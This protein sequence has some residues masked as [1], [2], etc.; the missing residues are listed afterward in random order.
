MLLAG[1]A[2]AVAR[3]LHDVPHLVNSTMPTETRREYVAHPW[4]AYLHIA[5][6][7]WLAFAMHAAFAEW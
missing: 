7:F 5:V 4:R 6:A 3:L 1:L 2:F